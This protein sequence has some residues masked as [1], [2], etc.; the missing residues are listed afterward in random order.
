MLEQGL[1]QLTIPSAHNA[2]TFDFGAFLLALPAEANSAGMTGQE[3]AF[4]LAPNRIPHDMDRRF[5]MEFLSQMAVHF[6][7]VTDGIGQGER[8]LTHEQRAAHEN[9]QR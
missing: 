8:G 3:L 4:E 1:A 9:K 7:A 5:L 6:G 2:S